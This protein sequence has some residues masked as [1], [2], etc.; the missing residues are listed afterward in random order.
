MYGR[1][2]FAQAAV[3]SPP[4]SGAAPH[5]ATDKVMAMAMMRLFGVM[6]VS[7]LDERRETAG[8]SFG[9]VVVPSCRFDAPAE[10]PVEKAYAAQP[11][12][13]GRTSC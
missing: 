1:P 4:A 9:P 2:V 10:R 5:P 6:S 8:N 7:C 11:L 3:A 13:S 12:C